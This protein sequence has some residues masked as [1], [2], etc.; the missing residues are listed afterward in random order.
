M[1]ATVTFNMIKDGIVGHVNVTIANNGY[2]LTLGNSADLT[3]FPMGNYSP[4]F[5]VYRTWASVNIIE[6]TVEVDDATFNAIKTYF[7]EIEGNQTHYGLYFGVNCIDFS[8]QIYEMTGAAGHFSELFSEQ[9]LAGPFAGWLI[10][11]AKAESV[12]ITS[13]DI[14]QAATYRGPVNGEFGMSGGVIIV[15]VLAIV[16]ALNRLLTRS[17]NPGRSGVVTRLRV[18][19]SG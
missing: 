16:V 11:Q 9:E 4:V 19:L 5:E 17:A 14:V 18:A 7:E 2:A 1:T 3:T 8:Q 6:K 10:R 15:G 13:N 12:F